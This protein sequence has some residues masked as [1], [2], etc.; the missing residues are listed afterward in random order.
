MAAL[1]PRRPIPRR[2]V[3]AIAVLVLALVAVTFLRSPF[4][5]DDA[6]LLRLHEV[7]V[8]LP[9]GVGAGPVRSGLWVLDSDNTLFGGYSALLNLP[10][11][12]LR[13][14]SDRGSTLT[15]DVPEE[16][17]DARVLFAPVW[18][19]GPL[20]TD[21]R[22]IESA[23]QEIGGGTYW[24]G[25][26]A[27]N[28][29]GHY[30]EDGSLIAIRQP[31]EWRFWP[32]NAGAEA[33]VRLADGRFIVL[34][35]SSRMGLLY[36]SDP[37]AGEVIGQPFA[38]RLPRGYRA[39][40]MAQLPDGRVLVLLRGLDLALP[41]FTSRLVIADPAQIADGEEW[42]MQAFAD[43]DTILPR[44]NWEG[45]AV[46]PLDD[47]AAA[48]WLISDDNNAVMQRTLLAKLI[49][50]PE[51]EKGARNEP[52]APQIPSDEES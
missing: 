21:F 32:A 45:M 28:A 35:E 17:G 49:W 6:Q 10:S 44:E 29:I 43:L 3:L 22:D 15:F 41:P 16:A 39:T 42:I 9:Q 47:D 30:R 12:Q 24:I 38:F 20:Q 31:P 4:R 7:E 37:V 40:D 8:G 26:E 19:I 51:T 50:Q 23:T 46:E 52:D 18:D 33:M 13:A 36:P 48:I 34:P 2:R 14:F 27:F 11:G 1:R 25:F 5:E